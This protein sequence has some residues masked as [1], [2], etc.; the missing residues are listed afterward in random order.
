[1]AI[2]IIGYPDSS[3][4]TPQTYNNDVTEITQP[5][6]LKDVIIELNN[7]STNPETKMSRIDTNTRLQDWQITN[8]TAWDTLVGFGVV[9]QIGLQIT[10]QMKVLL[11]SKNGEGRKEI[12]ELSKNNLDNTIKKGGMYDKAKGLFG[13]R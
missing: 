13:V 9:P 10:R 6:E 5:N 7:S 11:I 8:I 4:T 12:V 3:P 2:K 1:M